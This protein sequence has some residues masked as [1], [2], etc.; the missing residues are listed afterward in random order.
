VKRGACV[1]NHLTGIQF[2]PPD[3]GT[4]ALL[5]RPRQDV[6][7]TAGRLGSSRLSVGL[8]AYVGSAC[9]SGGVGARVAHHLRNK[10]HAYWHID[11][12][13]Q[14]CEPEAVC[15]V[16]GTERLECSWVQSLLRLPGACVPVP[17]FGSSDCHQGCPAH[18]VG[19]NSEFGPA[20]VAGTLA[21]IVTKRLPVSWRK[22]AP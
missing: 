6:V 10:Q 14:Q 15:W 16:I 21:S 5:L 19:V 22:V 11:S 13:T 20:E 3:S 8:Y 12:L 1:G 17:G 7:L 4:Y 2:L 18:L 9:G